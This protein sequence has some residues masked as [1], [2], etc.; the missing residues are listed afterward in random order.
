MDGRARRCPTPEMITAAHVH[1]GAALFDV[2]IS[3]TEVGLVGDADLATVAPN[4]GWLTPMPGGTG[5]RT[6][7]CLVSNTLQAARLQGELR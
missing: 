3:S 2:G 5:P 6:V 4:A 1:P 7:A